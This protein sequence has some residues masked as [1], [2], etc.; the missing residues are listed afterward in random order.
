VDH[1]EFGW[2]TVRYYEADPLA[3]DLDDE[4]IK[5]VE[6]E[7]QKEKEKRATK[8][9]Q[10]ASNTATKHRR[11]TWGDQPGP[12]SRQDNVLPMPPVWSGQMQNRP[13]V[14]GPC[15]WCETMGHL[16]ASCTVKDKPY[17]FSQPV[18]CSAEV[19]IELFDSHECVGFTV[20][21]AACQRGAKGHWLKILTVKANP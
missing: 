4:F 9:R 18:V 19:N 20:V 13:R 10:E 16:A 12:S 5:K 7:A 3:A 11:A 2:A 15:F 21:S 1:S 6:K 8:W 14:L 17:P